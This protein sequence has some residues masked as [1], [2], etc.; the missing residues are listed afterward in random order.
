MAES[1]RAQRD[2]RVSG[3][4]S[5][6]IACT[7]GRSPIGTGS[8]SP[9]SAQS[10]A[11]FSSAALPPTELKTVLRLTPARSAIASTVVAA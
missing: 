11:S 6:I 9:T 1:N 4:V 2:T 3:S 10:Q 8:S 7:S 5:A